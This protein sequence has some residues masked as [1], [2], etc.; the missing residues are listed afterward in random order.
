[1]KNLVFAHNNLKLL[2]R[3]LREFKGSQLF[4]TRDYG[5]EVFAHSPDGRS[6]KHTLFLVYTGEA[7]IGWYEYHKRVGEWVAD[8]DGKVKPVAT[9]PET[10]LPDWLSLPDREGSR[11]YQVAYHDWLH[12]WREGHSKV[13]SVEVNAQ[14]A[15]EAALIVITAYGVKYHPYYKWGEGYWM[16]TINHTTRVEATPK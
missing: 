15:D 8:P 13:W 6:W 10:P 4:A 11:V 14:S 5:L 1:M 16:D 9:P 12:E 7:R 3:F 2:R